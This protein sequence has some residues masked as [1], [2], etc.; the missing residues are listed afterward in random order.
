MNGDYTW[1]S[2]LNNLPTCRSVLGDEARQELDYRN[3]MLQQ[4]RQSRQCV[5]QG[6]HDSGR[7]H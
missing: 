5:G 4:L 1:L 3:A 2:S 7:A 6:R